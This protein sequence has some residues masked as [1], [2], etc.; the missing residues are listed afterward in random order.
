MNLF[1]EGRQAVGDDGHWFELGGEENEGGFYR[2]PAVI[3]L[4]AV[5]VA[6]TAIVAGLGGIFEALSFRQSL[7]NH[8]AVNVI[9]CFG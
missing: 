6:A 7:Q 4:V 9:N 2:P 5:A 8:F 3:G 1:F